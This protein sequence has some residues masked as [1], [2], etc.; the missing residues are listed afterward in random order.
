MYNLLVWN[1]H[2]NSLQLCAQGYLQLATPTSTTGCISY[3]WNQPCEGSI[4]KSRQ[5][6]MQFI[7]GQHD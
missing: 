7:K 3:E 1:M 4:S 2:A 6:C 5:R